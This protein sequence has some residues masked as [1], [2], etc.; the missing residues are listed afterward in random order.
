MERGRCDRGATLVEYA[1]LVALIAI[2]SIGAVQALSDRTRARYGE[3]A[4]DIGSQESSTPGGPSGG[5]PTTPGDPGTGDPGTGDPGTGDPGTGDPGTGDPGTGDPGSGDPGTGDPGT[6]DSDPGPT[7]STT[8]PTPGMSASCSR[9]CSFSLT[10]LQPGA[11]VQW[12][13]G[14]TNPPTVSWSPSPST[15]YTQPNGNQA[16]YY[17]MAVV[18]PGGSSEVLEVSCPNGNGNCTWRK[19]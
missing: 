18:S 6:G 11:T 19:A 12:F 1:L 7:T 9:T 17:V 16:T 3:T 5:G 4:A 13:R 10:N 8:V 14:P 15:S 2:V